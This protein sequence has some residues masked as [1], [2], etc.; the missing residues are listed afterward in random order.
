VDGHTYIYEYPP[1][2]IERAVAVIK[3]H[4]EEGR[5]HPYAGLLLV[6]MGRNNEL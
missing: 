6:H 4:V 2:E 1:E 5:L 3:G